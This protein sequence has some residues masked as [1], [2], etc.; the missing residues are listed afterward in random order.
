MP[1]CVGATAADDYRN[2]PNTYGWVVEIDPFDGR[3]AP[4]KRTALGRF[5]SRRR[6]ASAPVVAG[7]PLAWYMGDDS[8][9]EYV[10]KFVSARSWDR[11]RRQRRPSRPAT[12]T[13]TTASSTSPGST[14]TAPARGSSWRSASTAS[15]AAIR[16]TPSPIQADV[17]VNARLAADAAG[18]TKMDRPEWTAVESDDRRGLPDADQQQCGAAAR[19]TATDAANPRFYNDPKGAA[20]RR[21]TAIP[22][23]T[24]SACRNRRRSGGDHLHLGHLPVRRARR[25]DAANVNVSGLTADNDF[26]SPDGLWFSQATP[27][28]LLDP[29]RRRRLHRRHQLHDARGA[30]GQRS[31]TAAR[32]RSPT[33]T[34]TT[35][36]QATFVGK[37][38][39]ADAAALPGRAEGLR[40]HRHRRIAGRPDAVRQH[41]APGRG[42]AR[43]HRRPVEVRQPLARWRQRATALGHIGDHA[44]RRRAGRD[45]MDRLRSDGTNPPPI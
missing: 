43:R 3:G 22:T 27:G 12:S 21:R 5:G 45:L 36:T 10:Y 33:S 44:R 31:A 38:P 40:D 24:S 9:S 6:V 26:S 25:R 34:A 1:R 16:P 18:A 7:K 35:A 20:R 11:G 39:G 19:S 41:P 14:P 15:T 32:R 13:S 8:R 29:D 30:A 4:R 17:V 23:A 2:E 37:A 42:D 28:L